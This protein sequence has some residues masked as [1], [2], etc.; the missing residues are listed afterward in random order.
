[1]SSEMRCQACGFNAALSGENSTTTTSQTSN[2][3]SKHLDDELITLT[4]DELVELVK[5]ASQIVKNG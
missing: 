2:G 1:M 5:R 4:R 3:M